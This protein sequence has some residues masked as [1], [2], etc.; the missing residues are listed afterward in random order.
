M[1][2][3]ERHST[4]TEDMLDGLAPH[5]HDFKSS[6]SGWLMRTPSDVQ[7]DF[8]SSP[9]SIVAN[10]SG[11]LYC[12]HR[13]RWTYRRGVPIDIKGGTRAWLEDLVATSVDHRYP[14]QCLRGV[15]QEG[16]TTKIKVGH[17]VYVIELPGGKAKDHRYYLR[18]AG[19]SRPMGHV[20]VQ[21]V[22][23]ELFTQIELARWSLRLH[24]KDTQDHAAGLL[25]GILGECGRT[26]RPSWDSSDVPGL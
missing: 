21:D 19:K 10:G 6:G 15:S 17:G 1:T 9:T 14:V 7:P 22:L 3:F 24:E 16:A 4:W 23:S 18:I 25:I 12:W 5:E 13:R 2:Q 26:A 11:A 8:S 20:H